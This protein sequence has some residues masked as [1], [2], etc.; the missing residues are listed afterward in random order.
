MRRILPTI[1]L[2]IT[3][4]ISTP[5]LSRA[6]EVF[7]TPPADVGNGGGGGNVPPPMLSIVTRVVNDNAG[8]KGPA[9]FSATVTSGQPSVKQRVTG[10]GALGASLIP[11]LGPY[12]VTPASDPGYSS[13]LSGQ[14]NGT[15]T[16][17]QSAICTIT[18]D[19]LAPVPEM[20]VSD[21][22]GAAP[23][24]GTTKPPMRPVRL[25]PKPMGTVPGSASDSGEVLSATGSASAVVI[26][27]AQGAGC[28][29]FWGWFG[30]Y[31]WVAL[32]VVLLMLVGRSVHTWSRT[33][34]KAKGN[35]AKE[36][37]KP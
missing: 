3:I 20:P 31:W 26:N 5:S 36:E 14:C 13:V 27:H 4:L 9:D 29:W 2:A 11:N 1:I 37:K 32:I 15:L 16:D 24:S 7:D 8:A 25:L 33:D 28:T 23:V 18:Y 22:Q 12:E 10:A 21:D 19:D 17:G 6:G 30:C 34:V 35:E